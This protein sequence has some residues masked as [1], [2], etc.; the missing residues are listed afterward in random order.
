MRER[1][2][3][4]ALTVRESRDGGRFLIQSGER[5]R[6]RERAFLLFP[7]HQEKRRRAKGDNVFRV[8][9]NETLNVAFW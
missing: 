2:K 6:E 4:A 7:F 1:F 5:E 3:T 9:L 8:C